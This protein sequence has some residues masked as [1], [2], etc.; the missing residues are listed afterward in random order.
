MPKRSLHKKLWRSY[1]GNSFPEVEV[2]RKMD[3]Y[4]QIMPG[5]KHREKEHDPLK[6]GECD[7]EPYPELDKYRIIYKLFHIAVDWWWSSLTK[8]S[9]KIWKIKINKDI[10]PLVVWNYFWNLIELIVYHPLEI[11]AN[12]PW[13]PEPLPPGWE[14]YIE[15]K[16]N[17]NI[18]RF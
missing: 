15:S 5:M 16:E 6:T 4:S 14:E 18:S 17:R 2:D 8:E 1:F 9:K 3:S 11:S 12:L 7:G 10:K 13:Q